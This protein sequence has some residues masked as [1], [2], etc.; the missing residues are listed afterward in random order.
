MSTAIRNR[1]RRIEAAVLPPPP[2]P[3]KVIKLLAEP[4][5]GVTLEEELAALKKTCD[6]VIVLSALKGPPLKGV[7]YCDSEA[8]AQILAAAHQPSV[9]GRK[10]HLDDV[11]VRLSGN[12]FKPVTEKESAWAARQRARLD[13]DGGA[14]RPGPMSDE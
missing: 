6:M 9:E 3:P 2:E 8:E 1:V 12:V 14:A 10:S 4:P 11:L 7:E 13:C 5:P